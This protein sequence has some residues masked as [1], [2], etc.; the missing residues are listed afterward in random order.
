MWRWQKPPY[1]LSV[2]DIPVDRD[3]T[4]VAAT[5]SL[6][7]EI[8]K[9]CLKSSL[10]NLEVKTRWT[11]VLNIATIAFSPPAPINTPLSLIA[12]RKLAS[13]ETVI[14]PILSG[15]TWPRRTSLSSHLCRPASP[16]LCGGNAPA[17]G[18]NK[19][20]LALR[21]IMYERKAVGSPA[22]TRLNREMMSMWFT[23]A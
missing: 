22:P 15:Q 16:D 14:Q 4:I 1:F 5:C 13:R 11:T 20:S 19:A 8:V 9:A 3:T 18:M 12:Q 10:S 6:R 7:S 23:V 17:A 2:A 21:Y